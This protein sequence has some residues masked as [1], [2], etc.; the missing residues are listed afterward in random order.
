M[1]NT[2]Y[3]LVIDELSGYYRTN[4]EPA[5]S[6]EQATKFSFQD[7]AVCLALHINARASVIEGNWEVQVEEHNDLIK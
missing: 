5:V 6:L 7:E 3:V 4:D 1:Y 2:Y